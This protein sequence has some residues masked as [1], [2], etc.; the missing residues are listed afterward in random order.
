ML[1]LTKAKVTRPMLAQD[2]KR[3][4]SG[5]P[6]TRRR[7]AHA[8]RRPRV[9]TPVATTSRKTG[10]MKIRRRGAKPMPVRKANQAM[11]G[12]GNSIQANSATLTARRRHT[13]QPRP[14]NHSPITAVTNSGSA[15]HGERL[16]M[17]ASNGLLNSDGSRSKEAASVPASS[18]WVRS[19]ATRALPSSCEL[20][21]GR[22]NSPTTTRAIARCSRARRFAGSRHS[23]ATG[24]G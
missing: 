2:A 4:S 22:N 17:K 3:A 15:V 14:A 6:G 1:P 13:S 12:K 21:W 24:P 19:A 9:V 11:S 20:S 7:T 23:E 5:R 18:A 10:R 16:V 8:A